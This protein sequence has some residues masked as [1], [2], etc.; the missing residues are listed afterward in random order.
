MSGVGVQEAVRGD[1][2]FHSVTVAAIRL[3]GHGGIVLVTHQKDPPL[4]FWCG[5]VGLAELLQVVGVIIGIEITAR[6]RRVEQNDNT[7]TKN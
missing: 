3:I 1:I 4:A 2:V 6:R 5:L 7:D